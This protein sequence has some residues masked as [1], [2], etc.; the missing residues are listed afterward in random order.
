MS[1]NRTPIRGGSMIMISFGGLLLAFTAD[2]MFGLP[3]GIAYLL[4]YTVGLIAG[5]VGIAE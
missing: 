2:F 3:E 5:V 1:E 4:G